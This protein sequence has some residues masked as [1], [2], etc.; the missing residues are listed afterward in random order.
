MADAAYAMDAHT[1]DTHAIDAP[2]RVVEHV[3]PKR[4]IVGTMNHH[5]TRDGLA[6]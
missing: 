1:G 3:L 2:N 4:G 6:H 5:I